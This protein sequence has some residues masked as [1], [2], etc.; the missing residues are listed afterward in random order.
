M[1]TLAKQVLPSTDCDND[2]RWGMEDTI[3]SVSAFWPS[4]VYSETETLL[5]RF[6]HGEGRTCPLG[7]G[8]L[9]DS[10]DRF[11]FLYRVSTEG[12]LLWSIPTLRRS[13]WTSIGIDFNM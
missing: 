7:G 11:E 2:S 5:A 6:G 1:S 9:V 13:P 12:V 8:I 10:A 3:G 4:K